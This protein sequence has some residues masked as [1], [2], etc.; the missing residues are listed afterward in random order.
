MPKKHRQWATYMA[1][2]KGIPINETLI[3]DIR[4]LLKK[5]NVLIMIKKE[6]HEL[7]PKYTQGEKFQA[8]GIIFPSEIQSGKLI[9]SVVPD[10][11]YVIEEDF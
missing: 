5:E 2:F 4:L 11:K 9:I 6:N 7:K 3:S 10:I 1:Y 8:L